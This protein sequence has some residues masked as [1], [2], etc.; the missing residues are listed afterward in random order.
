MPYANYGDTSLYVW[1][2][3][4]MV[5]TGGPT[6][7][8]NNSGAEITG[9]IH[10]KTCSFPSGHAG[11]VVSYALSVKS[12]YILNLS[13]KSSPARFW[14]KQGSG[15]S[16]DAYVKLN[17]GSFISVNVSMAE[18]SGIS[19]IDT[20]DVQLN[21]EGSPIFFGVPDATLTLIT[22]KWTSFKGSQETNE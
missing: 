5:Q 20:L 15:G 1:D 12:G 18:W 14:S 22:N 7:P 13:G 10:Y 2:V 19:S 6:A 17:G 16:G 8:F 21:A 9:F 3:Y 11:E 4:D